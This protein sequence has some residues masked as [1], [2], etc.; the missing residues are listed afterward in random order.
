MANARDFFKFIRQSARAGQVI[1]LQQDP[2]GKYVVCGYGRHELRP[3]TKGH[4]TGAAALAD[5]LRWLYGADKTKHQRIADL[6]GLTTADDVISAVS[7]MGWSLDPNDKIPHTWDITRTAGHIA[8][9]GGSFASPEDY[10]S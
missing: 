6:S 7:K 3:L 9:L 10:N 4:L 8:A 2:T 1:Q 5:A